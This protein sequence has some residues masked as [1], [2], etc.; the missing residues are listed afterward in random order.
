MY[1]WFEPRTAPGS[2]SDLGQ[3]FMVP[4][5][6]EKIADSKVRYLAWIEATR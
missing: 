1:P 6:Q 4:G 3:L 5:V 2:A